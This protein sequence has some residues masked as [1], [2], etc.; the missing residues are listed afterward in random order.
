LH[1]KADAIF[2][3]LQAWRTEEEKYEA[4]EVMKIINERKPADL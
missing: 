3:L 4:E 1:R 2:L